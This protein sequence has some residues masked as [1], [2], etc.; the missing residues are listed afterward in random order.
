MEKPTEQRYESRYGNKTAPCYQ[1]KPYAQPLP[2]VGSSYGSPFYVF[3]RAGGECNSGLPHHTKILMVAH[4]GGIAS[5]T[6]AAGHQHSG[7]PERQRFLL[8]T[9]SVERKSPLDDSKEVLQAATLAPN[10]LGSFQE[11]VAC[12]LV[13]ASPACSTGTA[14]YIPSNSGLG[15]HTTG[16]LEFL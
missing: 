12:L 4:C 10:T 6:D 13:G 14:L 8:F 5:G 11:L 7:L 3:R 1:T 9:F 16:G 15:A 2:I